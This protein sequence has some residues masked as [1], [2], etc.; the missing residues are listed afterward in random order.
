MTLKDLGDRAKEFRFHSKYSR[1][2]MEDADTGKRN[3]PSN[4]EE[5]HSA[6]CVGG[7]HHGEVRS[8]VVQEQRT[9]A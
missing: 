6:A 1:D 5:D 2:A 9:V 8:S 4:T 3:D 7:R